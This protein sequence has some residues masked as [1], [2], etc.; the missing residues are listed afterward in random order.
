[1][2]CDPLFPFGKPQKLGVALRR[3]WCL[4]VHGRKDRQGA[5]GKGRLDHLER[6]C[7]LKIALVEDASLQGNEGKPSSPTGGA[8]AKRRFFQK[9]KNQLAGPCGTVS[10]SNG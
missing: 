8:S 6:R 2:N 5:L 7:G 10:G 4:E 9:L 1:M 3:K